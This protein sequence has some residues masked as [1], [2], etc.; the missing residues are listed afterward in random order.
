MMRKWEILIRMYTYTDFSI[1]GDYTKI[2]FSVAVMNW[3]Y[4]PQ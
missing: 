2:Y 4:V 1:S 3:A